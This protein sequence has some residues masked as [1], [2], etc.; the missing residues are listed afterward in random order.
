MIESRELTVDCRRDAVVELG[1]HREEAAFRL[2]GVAAS[3]HFLVVNSRV[4]RELA[5]GLNQQLRSE[6]ITS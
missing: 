3:D 6:E 1:E 4:A 5:P 2:D